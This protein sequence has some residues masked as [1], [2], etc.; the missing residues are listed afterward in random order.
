MDTNTIDTPLSAGVIAVREAVGI[1]EGQVEIIHEP[2]ALAII[3][4]CSDDQIEEELTALVLALKT[5]LCPWLFAQGMAFALQCVDGSVWEKGKFTLAHDA[6]ELS[7]NPSADLAGK[8]KWW[9]EVKGDKSKNPVSLSAKLSIFCKFLDRASKP[10]GPKLVSGETRA[11]AALAAQAMAMV[12]SG[13]VT[14]ADIVVMGTPPIAEMA[15]GE[16]VQVEIEAGIVAR[17][18]VSSI[19][20]AA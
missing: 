10:E 18:N 2:F 12:A 13:A 8:G 15:P 7:L 20:N 4:A 14:F 11:Q 16:A 17:D 1:I 3:A 19:S 9:L 5:P 6:D